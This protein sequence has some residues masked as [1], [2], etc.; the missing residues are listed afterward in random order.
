[1]SARRRRDRGIAIAAVL[2]GVLLLGA[3]VSDPPV[4]SVSD[5]ITVPSTIVS[6]RP[7]F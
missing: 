3:C 2:A 6:Q 7:A 1:M 5:E 4:T